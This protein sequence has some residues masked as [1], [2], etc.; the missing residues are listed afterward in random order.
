MS[1]DPISYID[2]TEEDGFPFQRLLRDSQVNPH[3]TINYVRRYMSQHRGHM[4]PSIQQECLKVHLRAQS[5][6]DRRNEI[7][8]NKKFSKLS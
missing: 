6:I 5:E 4:L 8:Q 3:E 1:K 7:Y 2:W